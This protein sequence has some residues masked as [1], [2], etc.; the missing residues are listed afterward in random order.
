LTSPKFS[1][2]AEASPPFCAGQLVRLLDCATHTQPI[3]FDPLTHAPTHSH[4][5]V[6]VKE[7]D[8]DRTPAVVMDVDP[9]EHEDKPYRLHYVGWRLDWDTWEPASRLCS[10]KPGSQTH[11]RTL[12]LLHATRGVIA[13]IEAAR[14]QENYAVSDWVDVR[15]D[16]V[17]G[18]PRAQGVGRVIDKSFR[19]VVDALS[20]HRYELR[21]FVKFVLTKHEGYDEWV[22]GAE[23]LARVDPPEKTRGSRGEVFDEVSHPDETEIEDLEDLEELRSLCSVLETGRQTPERPE[24]EVERVLERRKVDGGGYEY[25]VHW[26]RTAAGEDS[27]EP[28]AKLSA[29]A[30]EQ[31]DQWAQRRRE[32]KLKKKAQLKQKEFLKAQRDMDASSSAKRSSSAVEVLAPPQAKRAK[33][34]DTVTDASNGRAEA[35]SASNRLKPNPSSAPAAV[36]SIFDAPA[37]P[38]PAVKASLGPAAAI[39]KSAAAAPAPSPRGGFS[40]LN[41]LGKMPG[42]AHS[43]PSPRDQPKAAT[44]ND[45]LPRSSSSSSSASGGDDDGDSTS[46]A[47]SLMMPAAST[48]PSAVPDA[49]PRSVQQAIPSPRPSVSRDTNVARK[50]VAPAVTPVTSPTDPETGASPSSVI[51]I[52]VRSG[53]EGEKDMVFKIKMD[54]HLSKVMDTYTSK[55]RKKASQGKGGIF[56]G[57]APEASLHFTFDGIEIKHD[58]K[59]HTAT[60]LDMED[61]D[62][63]D[64]RI[65]VQAPPSHQRPGH[66]TAAAAPASAV[67][68]TA[69]PVSYDLSGPGAAT[70]APTQQHGQLPSR[71]SSHQ[72]VSPPRV[73]FS[74]PPAL[75]GAAVAGS[76]HQQPV[77]PDSVRIDVTNTDNS[78]Y[79]LGDLAVVGSGN[80]AGTRTSRAVDASSPLSSPRPCLFVPDCLTITSVGGEFVVPFAKLKEL[81]YLVLRPK[82]DDAAAEVCAMLSAQ[83]CFRSRNHRQTIA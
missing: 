48:V 47:P 45:T 74:P 39:A 62:M 82:V 50:S 32:E 56:A 4:T 37:K 65:I 71:A 24:R 51:R 72:I 5:Q 35:A 34:P 21:Y 73:D 19:A 23:I 3:C 41:R 68:A 8:L 1:M 11:K 15:R 52:K 6:L 31:L 25:K 44:A 30:S 9:D 79:K 58:D 54:T 77:L 81:P 61:D 53:I 26:A 29:S 38:K 46:H 83:L 70:S 80:G 75:G 66:D 2:A 60:G 13:S 63:I 40:L 20:P 27:W 43:R 12:R 55:M 59:E 78:L 17:K 22:R 69:P 42:A 49:M 64:V 67:A 18:H 10:R 16:R 33:K 76:Q 14:G 57:S 28:E 36:S 7:T